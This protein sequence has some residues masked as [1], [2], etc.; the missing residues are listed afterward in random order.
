MVNRYIE[1]LCLKWFRENEKL[2][3][4]LEFIVKFIAVTKYIIAFYAFSYLAILPEG[5]EPIANKLYSIAILIIF[6]FF[7]SRFINKFFQHDLI[8]QSKLKAVSKNLLPFVNKVIIALIWVV[9][10]IM[11]I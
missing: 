8:E 5:V 7:S 11:I 4:V 10:I 6:L 2:L 3:F 9:G 1:N